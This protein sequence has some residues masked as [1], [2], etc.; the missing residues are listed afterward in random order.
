M[1]SINAGHQLE[2]MGDESVS[3]IEHHD[4]FY[5]D[6]LFDH[7]VYRPMCT[8]IM[9]NITSFFIMFSFIVS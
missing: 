4:E 1:F 7:S 8:H 5:G 2:I 6:L 9:G 3:S